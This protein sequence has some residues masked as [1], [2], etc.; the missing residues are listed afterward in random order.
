[1][2]DSVITSTTLSKA[3]TPEEIR[4]AILRFE[5]LLTK[6]PGAF[7]GDENVLP[8]AHLFGY[9][10]YVRQLAIPRG[11]IWIGK[12]HKYDHA[13]FLLLGEILV[14]TEFDDVQH[15]KAP[16]YMITKAGTKK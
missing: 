1:M 8:L 5:S 10:L 9:G 12:I 4:N 15:Q 3:R 13:R 7:L 6:L 14:V 16:Y 11:C 2:C